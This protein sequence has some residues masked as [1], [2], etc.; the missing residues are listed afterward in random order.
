MDPVIHLG[1]RHRSDILLGLSG[2]TREKR[3]EEKASIK[4]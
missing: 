3:V 2:M 4:Q 1:E